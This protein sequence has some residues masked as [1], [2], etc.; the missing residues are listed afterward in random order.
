VDIE[1]SDNG[2]GIPEHMQTE[3]FELFA[4]AKSPVERA[5]ESLGIGLALVKQLGE[6]HGGAVSLKA[7]ALNQGSTFQVRLPIAS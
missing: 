7:R 6:L 2:M 5:Q 4:Q 1:V 3:I